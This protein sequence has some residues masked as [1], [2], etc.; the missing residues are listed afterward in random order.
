MEEKEE[1]KIVGHPRFAE[2]LAEL[3]K[4]HDKKNSDYSI[5]GRPLSNLEE[6][7][8]LGI[9]AWVGVIV[10]LTDKWCRIKQLTRKHLKG[11]A[12]AVKSESLLDTLRDNAIYSVLTMILYEEAKR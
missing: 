2:I 1:K 5:P 11:E 8:E 3:Q 6:A 9:P 7:E 12:P 10:R 4:L